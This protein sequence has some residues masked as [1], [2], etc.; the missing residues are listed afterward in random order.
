MTG[1]RKLSAVVQASQQQQRGDRAGIRRAT[2]A[3]TTGEAGQVAKVVPRRSFAA[4]GRRSMGVAPLE[5]SGTA[6]VEEK[7]GLF[8]PV[9]ERFHRTSTKPGNDENKLKPP[10]E[11]DSYA[12]ATLTVQVDADEK[13][14]DMEYPNSAVSGLHEGH[15]SCECRSCMQGFWGSLVDVLVSVVWG[16]GQ[17]DGFKLYAGEDVPAWL[18]EPFIVSGYRVYT[19]WEQNWRSMLQWHNETMNIHTHF[20]PSIFSIFA[21]I[22]IACSMH[23]RATVAD[24][25]VLAGYVASAGY[26]FMASALFHTHLPQSPMVFYQFCGVDTTGI[27]IA[28]AAT[29]LSVTYYLH[30]C[31]LRNL[32][33]YC[34]LTLLLTS[35]AMVGPRFKFWVAPGFS[36]ARFS[37]LSAV[38]AVCCAPLVHHL[39]EVGFA[40]V[41]AEGP[42]FRW[43]IAAIVF[44]LG[45]GAVFLTRFPECF[46]PG[47]FDYIGGSHSIWHVMIFLNCYCQARCV[48]ELFLWRL[49]SMCNA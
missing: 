33:I 41:V 8:P 47:T 40:G 12:A 2:W 38:I 16:S 15:E 22:F 37:C 9:M 32:I 46:S 10:S 20:I 23:P 48:Y 18:Q 3:P 36:Q 14:A 29:S 27:A 1:T 6:G 7:A 19:S 49:E 44:L 39:I 43:Q 30:I 35:L 28:V 17:Q 25:V 11:S 31:N 45:G 4:M 24:R 5:G 26:C 21:M 42:W 34:S 13:N